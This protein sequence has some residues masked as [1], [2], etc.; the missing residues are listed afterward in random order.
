MF[1]LE[2]FFQIKIVFGACNGFPFLFRL[3]VGLDDLD[4]KINI[5]PS[6]SSDN[7]WARVHIVS[8]LYNPESIIG[9]IL[10]LKGSGVRCNGCVDT[11]NDC[12]VIAGGCEKFVQ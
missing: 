3:C 1:D 12:K 11:K 10:C 6:L 4:L 5:I 2:A 9:L 8:N 7:S